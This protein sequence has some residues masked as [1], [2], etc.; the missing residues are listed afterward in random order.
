M[1][2]FNVKMRGFDEFARAIL[3]RPLHV[4][5]KSEPKINWPERT[6][7]MRRSGYVWAQ[8]ADGQFFMICDTC[9]GNCGQCGQS[10]TQGAPSMNM[11][12]QKLHNQGVS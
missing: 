8:S 10:K 7:D 4:R 6:E 1:T 9:G 5:V 2:K 11:L 3:G 12:I